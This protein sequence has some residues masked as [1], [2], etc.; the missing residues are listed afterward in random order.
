MRVITLES[1]YWQEAAKHG[2]TRTDIRRVVRAAAHEAN[3]Q[4]PSVS[5]FLNIVV[6]PL[7][8]YETVKETG[9]M[10]ITYSEEY[11]SIGFD[12]M[13]PHGAS[14]L[15]ATLRT[16]TLHE[17]VH[18]VSYVHVEAWKP[19]PLQAVVYEGLATV[20]E[21]QH[22]HNPPL[23]SQYEDDATMQEWLAEIKKLPVDVKNFD[24]LFNHPD[25][26]KWVIYKTG[27]WMIEKLLAANKHSLHD[28]VKMPH[29][30]VI[31]LF[32]ELNS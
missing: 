16:T 18:A 13:V 24:F 25:G 7:E 9:D 32:E 26:R 6:G 17:M 15:K 11:I 28:L 10:G 2:V 20:F 22:G 27:T 4:L 3:K 5:S 14:E 12:Y 29:E 30:D 21:K 23:W 8:P 31:A 19:A 1:K